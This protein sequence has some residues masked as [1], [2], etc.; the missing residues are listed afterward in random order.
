MQTY[1]LFIATMVLVI[2]AACSKPQPDTTKQTAGA[3]QVHGTLVQ[4]MRGIL[5]PASNVVFAVQGK[6][7]ADIKPAENIDPSTATD[8]F[9]GPYNGWL[10]VE[11]SGIALAEAANLISLPGRKCGNGHD[12]PVNNPDWPMLVQGLRDA[13]M[14]TYEAAKSKNPDSI[15]DAADAVAGA[16]A[17]C[18]DKYRDKPGGDSQR[19]M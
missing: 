11:N 16:C 4:V 18:H 8:P 10:A 15:Q 12:V 1:R 7:P 14:K 2:F 17:N 3:G 13:G 6:N 5:F 19:C 9:Q